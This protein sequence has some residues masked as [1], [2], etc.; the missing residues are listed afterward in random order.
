M[1]LN[2]R[3]VMVPNARFCRPE[4][5][6]AEV[7]AIMWDEDCGA[8]PVV[9]DQGDVTSMITDRDICIALGTRNKKASDVA[10]KDVSL[11][12]YFA[13]RPTRMFTRP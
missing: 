1:K 7:A 4:F 11:P 6:L 3:D 10:V 8:L 5:N 13:S 9:N 12:R 2:V